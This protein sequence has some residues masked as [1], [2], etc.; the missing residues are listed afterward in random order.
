MTLRL[1][2]DLTSS[3][4]DKSPEEI[5][6]QIL[7]ITPI[8]PGQ[9]LDRRFS[10]P[11]RKGTTSAPQ[12]AHSNQAESNLDGAGEE[13]DVVTD[14]ANLNLNSKSQGRQGNPDPLKR[15]DSQ[16]NEIDEFHDARS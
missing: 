15:H 2:Q 1:I 9:T 13:R 12:V 6:K 3:S 10:I 16:T 4:E 11:S 5:T 14:V 8:I 7:Q